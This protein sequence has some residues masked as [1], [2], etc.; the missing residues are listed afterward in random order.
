MAGF[1]VSTNASDGCGGLSNL[2]W[3][4]IPA[5]R[6]LRLTVLIAAHNEEACIG[7]TLDSVLAQRRQ[8]NRVVVAADNCTD[9][10]V[11]IVLAHTPPD[12]PPVFVYRTEHNTH[13]KPGALNQAW[14]ITRARTDLFVCIDADTVLPPNALWDWEQE[15]LADPVLAGCSAKFTM[16]SSTDMVALA[17]AGEV[18]SSAAALS[19]HTFRERMW[20]RIQKAE[21]S[22]WTD[23][24]LARRGRWT[25]VLAGTACA[26]RS[27]ALDRIVASRIERG[28]EAHPWSYL[29]EVE[30]FELTYR[31]RQMG[32][33]CR[34]SATVRAYTG[35]MLTL[36]T[37]WAQRMKWQTGTVRDLKAIGVNRMTAIDWWQQFLGLVS[38][39]LRVSWVTLFL[40]GV[41]Y[42]G[43][44]QVFRY[45]WVFPIVFVAC[46]VREAWRVPHRTWAD[47]AT[48][49]T[50][51]PQEIFAWIRA[52]WFTWSWVEVL[53]GRTRD[54]WALQIAAESR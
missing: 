42:T 20:T 36:K 27:S 3:E 15:F 16:L 14:A 30:D 26:I 44:L 34:V 35:S 33:V 12:S 40:F 47:V 32:Y 6:R 53:S 18:P 46:D 11:D 41:F 37:L 24:A 28:E 22:K 31:L 51:V 29:S 38:A 54:R 4:R 50:L 25:S 45:W 2:G 5:G 8:P 19:A 10:T 21:F 39:L 13:K 48:A 9:R 49:A 1:V 17:Q 52:A 7:A 23:T 43:H